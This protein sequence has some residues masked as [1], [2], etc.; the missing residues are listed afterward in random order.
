MYGK[1]S[2]VSNGEKKTKEDFFYK[3]KRKN[4]KSKAYKTKNHQNNNGCK[5]VELKQRFFLKN[6]GLPKEFLLS[7]L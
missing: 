5:R 4:Q 1:L 6:N 7:Y 2:Q 3:N